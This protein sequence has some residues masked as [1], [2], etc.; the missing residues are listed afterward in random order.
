MGNVKVCI[1]LLTK[2]AS[3]YMVRDMENL[4]FPADY[5][6][7]NLQVAAQPSA[8]VRADN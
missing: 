7:D 6:T 5:L 3:V 2:Y 4:T 1:C 8:Y